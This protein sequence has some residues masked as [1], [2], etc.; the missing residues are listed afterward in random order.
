MNWSPQS[1]PSTSSVN[2]KKPNVHEFHRKNQ[3]FLQ[4]NTLVPTFPSSN[5]TPG[6]MHRRLGSQDRPPASRGTHRRLQ[7]ISNDE[8]DEDTATSGDDRKMPAQ[9]P[10]SGANQTQKPTSI[11]R[12]FD[13]EV[14][15]DTSDSA[16]GYYDDSRFTSDSAEESQE[17]AN[18]RTALLPPSGISTN[19]QDE[20]DSHYGRGSRYTNQNYV[21]AASGRRHQR[22]ASRSAAPTPSSPSIGDSSTIFPKDSEAAIS[23]TEKWDNRTAQMFKNPKKKKYRRKSS[24]RKSA[25]SAED[26]SSSDSDPNSSEE[27]F[28]YRQWTKERARMLEKERSKLIQQWKAEARAEAESMRKEEQSSHCWR[29]FAARFNELGNEMFRLS[30]LIEAFIGNLPLT[31]G[32]VAMAVVTLGV[33]WFKFA[34]EFLDSCEPVHFHSSQC[35]FP[36]FPGCFYCDTTATGYKIAIG[37]HYGCKIV[38]GFLALVVVAK[39]ILATRVVMD[40]MSS[41]TTS[42]PAGLLCM[43]AVCVFAGRGLI[44]QIV[45]SSA[46][47]IHLCLAIWFIYMALAYHIMP[48]PSWFPN[49]VGIGISA[50]KTWLYYPMPGHLLMAISLSLNFFFFPISLIRVA[51]NKKISATVG[52]MQMSAPAISLYALTIMAQPSFEEEHPDV[53][54]FQRVHRMVYL[55]CMHVMCALSIL[56][57]VA[58]VHSLLVRWHDFKTKEFSPAH[59]AFCFPTLSHA[60]AIQVCL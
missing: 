58:S 34:E 39:I 21:T 3:E 9:P 26:E 50:V 48:E 36:E 8:W 29:L 54:N 33:V 6:M 53:T 25:D 18:E 59:A 17:E 24:K 51:V 49:T 52:W 1:R 2:R 43:T 42:S 45:V 37:F 44:G 20:R 56:G 41:P 38:S 19:E 32:A 10:F 23:A 5:V 4:R 12:R 31:I 22:K 30:T 27:E 40:E 16:S 60:N 28:D 55:P 13:F 7:S 11:A 14:G 47:C 46:A 35:T 15:E 57:M